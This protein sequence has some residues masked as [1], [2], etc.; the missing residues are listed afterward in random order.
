MH[1]PVGVMKL[2]GVEGH[3]QTLANVSQSFRCLMTLLLAAQY[4]HK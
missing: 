1:V 4:I 2:D 3:S